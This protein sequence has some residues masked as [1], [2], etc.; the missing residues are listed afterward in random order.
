MHKRVTFNGE[1]YWLNSDGHPT[2]LSPLDHFDEAGTCLAPTDSV[3]YAIVKGNQI[4]R[5]GEV[6][7]T[8]ADLKGE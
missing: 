6:I 2:L 8:L 5:F 7:G 1:P 4:I 3:S